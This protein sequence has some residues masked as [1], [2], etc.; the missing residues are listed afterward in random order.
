VTFGSIIF[1]ILAD[2]FIRLNNDCVIQL[3]DIK[4]VIGKIGKALELGSWS[5]MTELGVGDFQPMAKAMT[6]APMARILAEGW[7]WM[8]F[9]QTRCS[10]QWET[11]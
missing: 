7:L 5:T 10:S 1:Q 3:I 9:S 6:L 8:M 11:I 4:F 2:S